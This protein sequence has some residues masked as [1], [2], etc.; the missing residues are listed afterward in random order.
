MGNH[1]TCHCSN[2]PWYAHA[3]C[4]TRHNTPRPCTRPP[5]G[6]CKSP[7]HASHHRWPVRMQSVASSCVAPLDRIARAKQSM[8]KD[9][10]CVES[11]SLLAPHI[12]MQGDPVF[13][14]RVFATLFHNCNACLAHHRAC[15]SLNARSGAL[16]RSR[17]VAVG[18]SPWTRG[19]RT[20]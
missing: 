11:I 13:V 20:T 17:H 3:A 18:S 12:F 10:K 16:S 5:S 6:F 15:P 9:L 1:V 2:E 14:S 4:F 7:L 8:M 19:R